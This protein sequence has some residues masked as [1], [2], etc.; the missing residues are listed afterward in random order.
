[1]L[2][3]FALVLPPLG[4]AGGQRSILSEV[5][6]SL[7]LVSGMAAVWSETQVV[8]RIVAVVTFATLTIHWLT[9]LAPSGAFATWNAGADM[10]TLVLFALV[11]LARVVRPGTITSSRIQGAVAVYL[12]FGLVWANA[13]EWIQLIRP[14]AFTGSGMNGAHGASWIYYSFITLTTVGYG[15]ISPVH[16]AARSFA[17]A[18]ALTGQLYIAI[19]IS[20]LVALEIATRRDP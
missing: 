7:L 15:D 19:L 5:I 13:Y 6:L 17:A 2:I 9:L 16:P 11:V 14:G 20:R 12:L 18:E 10:L 4:V 3:L 8:F 1:M